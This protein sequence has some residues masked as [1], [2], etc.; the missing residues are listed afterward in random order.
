[1]TEKN[2]NFERIVIFA[3]VAMMYLSALTVLS[4]P[5]SDE[6]EEREEIELMIM[7]SPPRPPVDV[8]SSIVNASPRSTVTLSNVPTS[9]WT[10]G[11]SA[12][13]AGMIFG[14][15]DRNG[16]SNMYTGPA[17]DGVCPLF[18]LGQGK[19]GD[20]GYPFAGSCSIIVTAQGFD[21]RVIRGHTDDYWISYGNPGPDPWVVNGWTEHTW[22]DCTT[23]FMGTNQW[24]W[25]YQNN[26]G[27]IDVNKDGS[28]CLW[29]YSGN[30]KLYDYIPPASC[31]LPQTSLAHGM[32][33]FAESRGYAVVFSGGN[34]QVYTQKTDNQVAGGFSFIDF[35]NEID[36]GYP[37]M[38]QLTGHSMV[39]M[40][41]D[42]STSPPTIYIHDTWGNYVA[43]MQWGGSYSGM[44]L[45]AVTVIHLNPSGNAPPMS[46]SESPSTGTAGVST[47]ISQLSI[48]IDDPENNSFDWT[49]ET[50]PDIGSNSGTGETDGT[51]TCSISGLNYSMT[52]TWYV[53]ATDSLPGG[54]GTYTRTVYTFITEFETEPP[55]ITNVTDY[56]DPQDAGGYVNI[57]CNVTDN[58]GVDE[59]WVNIT[60]PVPLLVLMI[61]SSGRMIHMVIVIHHPHISSP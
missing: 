33:L 53:N 55:E 54:S 29:T 41:Y 15:Y 24:K 6:L 34:Y 11:C 5:S 44:D 10:Q 17:N 21:G 12:T 39:G 35:Q 38:V 32:R 7:D 20:S 4:T 13:S 28:T 56:P 18:E 26:D 31:G 22:G 45:K 37:V 23:D 48:Y 47:S 36:N 16:Y 52:Y 8:S 43:E 40:G 42:A 1:M 27:V 60:Y 59:V 49:I 50:V 25:D 14:Y 61:I 46:S 57:T 51:K 3:M 19:P 58:V 30:T 9:R 2:R